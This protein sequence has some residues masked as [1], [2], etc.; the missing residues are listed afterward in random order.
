MER[1]PDTKASGNR[2]LNLIYKVYG[3]IDL[4]W[5][6]VIVLAV[7]CAIAAA[8]FILVPIFKNTSFERVCIC[9][10]SWIFMAV[11]IIA[12]C[13]K[14]L[15]SALKALVFFAV[16]RPLV[17]LIEVPFVEAGWSVFTNRLSWFVF[18]LLAFPAGFIGWF[19]KKRNW[20]SVGILAPVLIAL[21][22]IA[23]EAFS[24][25]VDDF[26]YLMITGI[27][28]VFHV[29]IYCIAFFPDTA[30]RTIGGFI[31]ASTFIVAFIYREPDTIEMVTSL[32]GSPSYSADAVIKVDEAD[33]V[34]IEFDSTRDGLVC[35]KSEGF[36]S[37]DFVIT[38]GDTET[39]YS[40]DILD[41]D[42][43]ADIVITE[44]GDDEDG[45]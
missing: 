21:S 43:T 4:T 23:F 22:A 32:P 19:M 6:G 2:I 34:S 41:D 31:I 25:M 38:D 39:W 13:K 10:E 33:K 36:V 29:V 12:N 3:G 28:C 9:F 27:L 35:V 20:L 14:P 18:A 44:N 15:E 17:C 8:M 30:K 24:K 26:P 7:G 45:N 11:F 16:S 5:P 42:G 40:I 1:T 37:T